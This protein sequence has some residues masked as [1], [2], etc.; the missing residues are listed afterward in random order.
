MSLNWNI[1][2]IADH[3][4]LKVA[5]GDNG[6]WQ[7]D[8]VTEAFVWA[9]MAT[10]LSKNWTLDADYAPEF[11]ARIK[12]YEAIVGPIVMV[13]GKARPITW[14]DVQRR[15]GLSV[16]VS[17]IGRATFIKNVVSRELDARV[18]QYEREVEKA[19]EAA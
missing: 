3:D 6:E 16:N 14:E 2:E 5:V 9:S 12:V 15:V 10:G 8:A 18:R 1:G 13:K 19:A 4:E 17:P 11:F 7:L